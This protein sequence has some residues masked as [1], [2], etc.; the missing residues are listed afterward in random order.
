MTADGRAVGRVKEVNADKF[1]VDA[2]LQL[3]YWLDSSLV[4][5]GDRERVTLT[6][7]ESDLGAY[8]RIKGSVAD[9]IRPLTS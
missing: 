4:A 3:D 9:A 6:L 5:K 8:E 7:N 2:P 1:L